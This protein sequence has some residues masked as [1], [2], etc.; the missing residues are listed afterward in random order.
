MPSS[1]RAAVTS[2]QEK[3]YTLNP[4]TLNPVRAGNSQQGSSQQDKILKF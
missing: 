1:Q 2:R 3:T 4:K